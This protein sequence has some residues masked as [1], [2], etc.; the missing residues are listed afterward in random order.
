MIFEH[1]ESAFD[2]IEKNGGGDFEGNKDKN[3]IQDAEDALGVR[4]PRTYRKFL[5]TLGCGDIEGLEFFGVI[6]DDFENSGIPD[7]VWLTRKERESGLPKE[8][9]LIHATED[10]T[11]LALDTS[12]MNDSEECPVVSCG[13]D[14]NIKEIA[15]DF[16]EFLFS[17]L[18]AA[19]SD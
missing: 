11:Y 8:L 4:F 14:G 9:V 7:A 18:K 3:L 15:S 10:G 13:V 12:K 19:L 5:E 16:G 17:E 1:L 6:K 2:L